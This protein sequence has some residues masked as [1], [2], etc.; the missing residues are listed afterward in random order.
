MAQLVTIH[1]MLSPVPRIAPRYQR[2][3]TDIVRNIMHDL[4]NGRVGQ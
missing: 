3:M 2:V 1:I 4:R